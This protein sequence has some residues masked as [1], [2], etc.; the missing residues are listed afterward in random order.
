MIQQIFINLINVWGS[1][2]RLLDGRAQRYEAVSQVS[3]KHQLQ[4]K[5]EPDPMRREK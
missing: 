1:G 3:L 2:D 4:I 5:S